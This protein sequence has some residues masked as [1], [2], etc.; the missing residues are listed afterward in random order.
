MNREEI[1]R[2]Y[3]E[4]KD[5]VISDP[6]LKELVLNL[7]QKVVADILEKHGEANEPRV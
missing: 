1:E 6:K 2:Y 3:E 5:L 7:V 4:S